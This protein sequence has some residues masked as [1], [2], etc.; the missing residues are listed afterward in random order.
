MANQTS[1]NPDLA[2]MEPSP[3]SMVGNIAEF[4]N[5]IATLV[6]LQAKLAVIDAK[7]CLGRATL[8]LIIL[9][10]G[11]AVAL[12]SLPVLL[13][14]TADLL[15]TFTNLPVWASRMIVAAVSLVV[16]ALVA[17]LSLREASGSIHSFRRSVDELTRNLSWV[18]TVLVHSGRVASRPKVRN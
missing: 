6:E 10:A 1:V 18:R 8:P 7:D 16:S 3:G 2:S 12:S 4:G 9:G 17:Y 14:G 13:L 5:D 15:T 11:A